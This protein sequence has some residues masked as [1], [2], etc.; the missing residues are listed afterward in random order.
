MQN[1]SRRA[2]ALLRIV[3]G[4]IFLWAFLDKLFGFGFAT[5]DGKSWLDG[6]SPTAGFLLHGTSGPFTNL[7]ASLA[8]QPWVDWL[9]MG[10]LLGIG[11]ALIL[12]IAM[13]LAATTGS[14]LLTLM[15]LALLWPKNNPFIDEHI[16]YILV[17]CILVYMNAG[18]TWGLG[19]WWKSLPLV[20]KMP[21]LA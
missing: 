13:R 5:P 2:P 7:F 12:G 18:D 17:L 3:M 4:W 21:W 6:A 1:T 9:F 10:G 15:Y 8:G 16:V 11:L 19:R 20:K 14:I